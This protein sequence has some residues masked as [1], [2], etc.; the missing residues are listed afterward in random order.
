MVLSAAYALLLA[1]C[2]SK[3]VPIHGHLKFKNGSDVSALNHYEVSFESETSKISGSGEVRSDGSFAITTGRDN[4][5]IPGRHRVA[6]TPPDPNPDAPPPKVVI[7]QKYRSFE[8]SGL[9]VD[10][11]PG[12]GDVTLE[13][14]RA[15]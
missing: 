3:T 11:K 4:G 5:A 2:S 12:A 6:I 7:P 1:G 15:P 8:T 9:T 10:V 13:V 14:D